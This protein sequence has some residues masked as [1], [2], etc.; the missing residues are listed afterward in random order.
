[1]AT[2]H[3]ERPLLHRCEAFLIRAS[4]LSSSLQPRILRRLWHSN[5]SEIF[6]SPVAVR[7][8]VI[9]P[10]ILE[11]SRKRRRRVEARNTVAGEFMD[12]L[13]LRKAK[14]MKAYSR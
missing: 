8:V 11:S 10:G 13:R 6:Q 9:R 5:R 7:V 3:M 1:M 2:Q 12:L 14:Q 4:R